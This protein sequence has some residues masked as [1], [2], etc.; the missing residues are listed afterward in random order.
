M[1]V[2]R[3]NKG[4]EFEYFEHD[5]DLLETNVRNVTKFKISK[6]AVDVTSE[7]KKSWSQYI[8]NR[9]ATIFLYGESPLEPII[10]QRLYALRVSPNV[11]YSVVDRLSG[12][13][14]NPVRVTFNAHSVFSFPKSD[15][16]EQESQRNEPEL[17]I[18][19]KF[20]QIKDDTFVTLTA[21]SNFWVELVEH[22]TYGWESVK[23]KQTAA[24]PEPEEAKL[25]DV[26][27][28]RIEY[29]KKWKK[30]GLG[31]EIFADN[32]PC[33]RCSSDPKQYEEQGPRK[34]TM[35][36]WQKEYEKYL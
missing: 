10:E 14:E 6:N 13:Q 20:E 1:P 29:I 22:I 2:F 15:D 11:E 33:S 8:T 31:P 23:N 18:E 34:S 21:P 32:N 16:E 9:S 19:F 5:T 24:Q 28:G 3:D 12:V 4:K 7:I 17:D 30:S 25:T 26:D 35:Y 36:R 27:H